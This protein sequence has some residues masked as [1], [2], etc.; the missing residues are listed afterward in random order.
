[1]LWI[2][3]SLVAI[4]CFISVYALCKIASDADDQAEALE[5]I[6]EGVDL[7]VTTD[8]TSIEGEWII[9]EETRR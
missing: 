7:S 2:G 8:L 6:E 4:S 3:L 9:N 5:N 1:M